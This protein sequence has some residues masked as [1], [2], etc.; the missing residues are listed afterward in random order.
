MSDQIDALLDEILADAYGAAEQ[1]SSFELAFQE[2]VR[3]PFAAQIVGIRVD[4]VNVEFD[5]DERHGLTALCK[6]DADK[7]RVS[8]QDLTPGP[9]PI[10]TVQLLEAYRRWLGLPPFDGSSDVDSS[11]PWTYRQV[12]S[13][14][15]TL[16]RPL[17]LQ[18]YGSWDPNEQ[19][20]GEPDQTIHP[21]YKAIIRAGPRPEFEMEQVIPGQDPD[22]W[23]SDPITN[24]RRIP[25]RGIES[26]RNTHPASGS[27]PRRTLHR[28]LGAP[29]E[30]RLRL[31]GTQGG[32]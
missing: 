25:P 19:Y 1:L 12:A 14:P 7:Y 15:S 3:F 28:C 2:S 4:V 9:A 32:I 27:R 21:L 5:G 23:D 11:G 31:E 8:V 30:Y 6:Q 18:P 26:G 22:N 16:D 24:A 10:E 17:E 13:V 29:R 20:W